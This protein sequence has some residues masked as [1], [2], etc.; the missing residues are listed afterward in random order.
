LRIL[1]LHRTRARDG[2]SVHI[3][4]LIAAFRAEGHA[5]QVVEPERIAA[6][7]TGLERKLLPPVLY[8]LCELGFSAVELIR[9]LKAA[10]G[11]KPDFLYQRANLHM[12]SG[13]LAAR[14]L[15]I[16][17]LVE[18]NAPLAEERARFG[19]L[20]WPKLAGWSETALWRSADMVLPVT[21]VLASYPARAGVKVS[22]IQVI[23]NGIDPERFRPRD[24]A[25]AK[26]ALGLSGRTVL[27]FVGYVRE[28]HGLE[29]VLDLLAADPRLALAHLVVVGDGPA[30]TALAARADRL[31]VARRVHFT[32]I[33]GRE[34]LA[35][36]ASAFDIALQPEVTPYASPLK[37]FEY[38]ALGHA[39]VAPDTANIREIL[40]DENDALLFPA[41]DNSA[42]AER[43]ARL[44]ADAELR[45]R[46]SA[47]AMDNIARNDRTWRGNARR[48]VTLAN[49]LSQPKKSPRT[50]IAPTVEG[51]GP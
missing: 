14:L 40:T 15:H 45:Q 48:I 51:A 24:R 22:A 30:T 42:F 4:E 33:I 43:V 25:A 44:A 5:V 28:W 1:Y 31:G 26:R 36:V 19:G 8:E 6:T 34:R 9:L 11:F 41:G 37:L 46:I 47:M 10:R 39:I 18:V 7:A 16:P 21:Q 50:E 13:V 29:Q 17:L 12:L 32:G 49:A 2:Q 20:A 27:G 35:D 38:M 23:A 3:D